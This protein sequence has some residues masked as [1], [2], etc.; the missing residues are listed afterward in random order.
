M[1][2]EYGDLATPALRV[3]GIDFRSITH[4]QIQTLFSYEIYETNY[5]IHALHS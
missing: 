5:S 3:G 4:R 1:G 2:G